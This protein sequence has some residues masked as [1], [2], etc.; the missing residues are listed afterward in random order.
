M[1][2]CKSEPKS[3][4]KDSKA[5]QPTGSRSSTSSGSSIDYG[6]DL[7]TTLAEGTD[8]DVEVIENIVRL[9]D[10]DNTI[11]FIARYRNEL[12][13]GMEPEKLR[14]IKEQLEELRYTLCFIKKCPDIYCILYS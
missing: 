12:T 11:P 13:K 1:T 3:P 8:C 9:L 14:E 4:K 7:S 5:K 10:D 2:S 6:W